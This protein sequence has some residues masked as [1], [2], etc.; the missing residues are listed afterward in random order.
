[1]PSSRES[2]SYAKLGA[3]SAKD[4][5]HAARGEDLSEFF[6]EVREDVA[7]D[8]DYYSMLH[9]DGAG[10]KSIVSYLTFRESNDP[11]WFKSLAQDCVVMNLD[12]VAC[13]GAFEGIIFNNTID[14]NRFLIPDEAVQAL[15]DGYGEFQQTLADAGL[16]IE[17][18]GGETADMGDVVRTVSL[19]STLFARVKRTE[20][21]SA[22]RIKAGDVI[23]GIS[24]VGQAS[25]ES[26]EN[27]SIGCNGFTLARHALIANKYAQKYPEILDPAVGLENGYQG[28]QDL[29]DSPEPLKSTIAEAML[30]PTRCYAPIVKKIVDELG[31]EIHAAI[32]CSGGGQTKISRF[33][34]NIRYVKDNLF[35]TPPIYSVI[36]ANMNIPWNEMYSVFNMGHRLE[37]VCDEKNV[38]SIV[39]ISKSFNIEAKT[40]G[41]VEGVDANSQNAD[42]QNGINSV[43]IQSP[44]GTFEFK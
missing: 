34:K 23:V 17:L 41:R 5:V 43:E 3:S 37:I 27:S 29:F 38:S 31:S 30:S 9:S 18:G 36:Q 22:K 42:S 14:R 6:A 4:A 1:M 2:E 20:A 13:V 12:D 25:F 8:P 24:G 39:D 21:I 33:G 32:H 11:K 19:N 28:K 26:C 40:I 35:E 44:Y 16:P 15:I 7:G 10:T